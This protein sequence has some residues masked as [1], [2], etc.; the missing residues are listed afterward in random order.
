VEE[1]SE[2]VVAGEAVKAVVDGLVQ[3][4]KAV[5]VAGLAVKVNPQEDYLVAELKE[6][7]QRQ[8]KRRKVFS[9]RNQNLNLVKQP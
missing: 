4:K 3:V 1:V 2:V 5:A 6:K 8:R 7:L 9:P